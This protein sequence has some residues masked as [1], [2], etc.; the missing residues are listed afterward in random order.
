MAFIPARHG[1]KN[2][3]R[4]PENNNGVTRV[5]DERREREKKRGKEK[6]PTPGRH[7][8]AIESIIRQ[9]GISGSRLSSNLV[10][11]DELPYSQ[12]FHYAIIIVNIEFGKTQLFHVSFN[13][14]IWSLSIKK[15]KL[16][17]K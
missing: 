7:A 2:T 9:N 10:N 16:K 8:D 5:L 11:R 14:R 13:F 6:C 17:L 15:L 4:R 12:Y 1:T 3:G